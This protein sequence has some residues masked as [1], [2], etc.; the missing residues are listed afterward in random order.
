MGNCFA[1]T[2]EPQPLTNELRNKIRRRVDP[3]L[4]RNQ[5]YSKGTAAGVDF[6][7]FTTE[8]SEAFARTKKAMPSL[9]IPETEI[10]FR[11]EK[12]EDSSQYKLGSWVYDKNNK[13]IDYTTPPQYVDGE[14]FAGGFIVG[15]PRLTNVSLIEHMADE[16]RMLCTIPIL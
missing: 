11:E 1:T 13:Q 8:Q 4:V 5:K 9:V 2:I 10:H 12:S 7:Y 15:I 14:D 3:V 16:N 6:A